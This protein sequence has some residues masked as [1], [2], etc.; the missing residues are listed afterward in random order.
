MVTARPYIPEAH[1]GRTFRAT[2]RVDTPGLPPLFTLTADDAVEAAER[3]GASAVY[4]YGRHP[5]TGAESWDFWRMA[6][7]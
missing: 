3:R 2:H 6:G 4:V 5:R 1:G 7:D